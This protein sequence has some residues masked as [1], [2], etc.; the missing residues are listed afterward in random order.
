MNKSLE[1]QQRYSSYRAILAATVSQ[2]YFV[3]VFMGYRTTIARHIAK[4]GIEQTCLCET[5]FRKILVSV[6]F[7]ARN[8]GPEMA[9]P[10]LWAPGKMRSLCRKNPAHKIPRF[11]GVFWVLG[12]GEVSILF[13][14]ARSFFLKWSGPNAEE[15]DECRALWVS[16]SGT[17]LMIPTTHLNPVPLVLFARHIIVDCKVPPKIQGAT[18]FER[19]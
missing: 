6:K 13:L 9:A 5:K 12:G 17:P 18:I 4:W 7:S 19:S 1:A 10:I 16:V 3:L 8:F 14:W 15:T 11:G 2:Q